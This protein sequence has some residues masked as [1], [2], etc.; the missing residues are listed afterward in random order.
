MAGALKEFQTAATLDPNNAT[1]KK[2]LQDLQQQA[3][4]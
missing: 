2:A 1:Y 3:S 4:H